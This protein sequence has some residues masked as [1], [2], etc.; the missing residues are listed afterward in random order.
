MVRKKNADMW[1]VNVRLIRAARTGRTLVAI[2]AVFL[3]LCVA[4]VPLVILLLHVI[5][6][7]AARL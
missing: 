5:G 2:G 1:R 6:R 4:P 7:T 3:R